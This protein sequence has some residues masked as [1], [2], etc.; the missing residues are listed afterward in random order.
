MLMLVLIFFIPGVYGFSLN[1]VGGNGAG[2]SVGSTTKIAAPDEGNVNIKATL[3]P[4]SASLLQSMEGDGEL[5]DSHYVDD[6]V[7]RA[8][9]YVDVWDY[10]LDDGNNPHYSYSYTLYP[11]EG[12]VGSSTYVS[13]GET[14]TVH[15]A[16]AI[17]A[18]AY[19]TYKNWYTAYAGLYMYSPKDYY[20]TGCSIEDYSNYAEASDYRA[21]ASQKFGSAETSSDFYLNEW[22]ANTENGAYH[23]LSASQGTL[24]SYS[25]KADITK[26]GGANVAADYTRPSAVYLED[27]VGSQSG[28]GY[29]SE[30]GYYGS[31]ISTLVDLST[32]AAK[33]SSKGTATTAESSLLAAGSPGTDYFLEY[34]ADSYNPYYYN[35]IY[36]TSPG[37]Y[38]AAAQFNGKKLNVNVAPA[39]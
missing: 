30:V 2:N 28:N 14:L 20:G 13:A 39:K 34:F 18:R 37:K 25:S 26:G 36:P 1:I 27:H 9:I 4:S 7:H 12:S 32:Y 19:A 15:N 11:G 8:D 6:N 16:D 17:D 38:S 24:G 23:R 35:Y 10:N 31:S 33:A 5:H 21:I 29:G 22:S 3:S